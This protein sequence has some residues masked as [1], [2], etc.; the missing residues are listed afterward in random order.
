MELITVRHYTE[1]IVRKMVGNRKIYAEQR[2][3]TTIQVVVKG[4]AMKN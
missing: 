3:R 2:T 1:D 4:D